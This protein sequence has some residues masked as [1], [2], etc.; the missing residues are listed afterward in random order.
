MPSDTA[1][2]MLT[3]LLGIVAVLA[4][5]GAGAAGIAAGFGGDLTTKSHW[6]KP[7]TLLTVATAAV[8]L[9][10]LAVRACITAAGLV[11]LAF[12]ATSALLPLPRATLRPA[13][14]GWRKA[15]ETKRRSQGRTSKRSPSWSPPARVRPPR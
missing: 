6:A 3:G 10:V 15:P 4:V 8:S 12:L 5:L 11:S 7:A 1:E 9:L 14:P 13:S 2:L